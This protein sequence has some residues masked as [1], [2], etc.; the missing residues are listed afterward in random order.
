MVVPSSCPVLQRV[1]EKQMERAGPD[2]GVEDG[3]KHQSSRCPKNFG[4]CNKSVLILR[5]G[6]LIV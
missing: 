3:E 4:E 5:E 2:N 6:S 1:T